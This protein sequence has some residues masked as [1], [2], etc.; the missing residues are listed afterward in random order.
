MTFYAGMSDQQKVYVA[1]DSL[2]VFQAAG[3]AWLVVLESAVGFRLIQA[4][5]MGRTQT[6]ALSR[7]TV[8][9]ARPFRPVQ[10]DRRLVLSPHQKA[11]TRSYVLT[12]DWVVS[13]PVVHR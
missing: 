3:K 2:P 6:P 13:E 12:R 7:P 5:A 4:T 9:A 8:K 11:E 10:I 1:I